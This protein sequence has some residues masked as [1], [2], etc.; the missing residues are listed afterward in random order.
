MHLGVVFR[1][2]PINIVRNGLGKGRR[3]DGLH[4]A[5]RTTLGVV[6]REM[7]FLSRTRQRTNDAMRIHFDDRKISAPT[8][9]GKDRIRDDSRPHFN[10]P[11]NH[12]GRSSY[13][14]A[15]SLKA[16]SLLGQLQT[17]GSDR[18]ALP[19]QPFDHRAPN[20]FRFIP[21]HLHGNDKTLGEQPTEFRSEFGNLIWRIPTHRGRLDDPQIGDMGLSEAESTNRFMKVLDT[22][23]TSVQTSLPSGL[24]H[25]MDNFPIKLT[26]V[27]SEIGASLVQIHHC[28][29]EMG[30]GFFVMPG[31][32]DADVLK[33]TARRNLNPSIHIN[34]VSAP[35]TRTTIPRDM[36][37]LVAVVHHH[38]R[39]QYRCDRNVRL[40]LR[41]L[42]RVRLPHTFEKTVGRIFHTLPVRR[43]WSGC[44]QKVQTASSQYATD[45]DHQD[46]LNEA[47]SVHRTTTLSDG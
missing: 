36:G 17:I 14:P 27:L 6:K 45:A 31:F 15:V 21:R 29:R 38:P 18:Q 28:T 9:K 11:A 1:T 43:G 24:F 22:L 47:T 37:F 8:S 19:N 5:Q 26:N 33:D 42:T 16:R 32:N 7:A 35:Y 4:S 13:L 3:Q 2:F 34:P 46:T 20:E 10:L 25:M 30:S 23:K 12:E 39:T 40:F 44:A 41:T